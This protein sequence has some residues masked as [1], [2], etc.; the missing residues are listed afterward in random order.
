MLCLFAILALSSVQARPI[1]K[2]DSS[3]DSVFQN[4][5]QTSGA[6]AAM[7]PLLLMHCHLK[8]SGFKLSRSFW[9]STDFL[10]WVLLGFSAVIWTTFVFLSAYVYQDMPC[11]ALTKWACLGRLAYVPWILITAFCFWVLRLAYY[12]CFTKWQSTKHGGANPKTQTKGEPF[13]RWWNVESAQRLTDRGFDVYIRDYSHVL[14]LAPVLLTAVGAFND[15]QYTISLLNIVGVIIFLHG[16]PEINVYGTSPHTYDAHCIRIPL[17]TDLNPSFIYILPSTKFGFD[18]VYSRRIDSEYLALDKNKADLK[19]S[20]SCPE[21]DRQS[22]IAKYHSA[23]RDVIV[24]HNKN[25]SPLPIKELEH[26]A[27]WLCPKTGDQPLQLKT[28]RRVKD[29]NLIGRELVMALLHCEN[30]VFENSL[31]LPP[32]LQKEV[33]KLR[34]AENGGITDLLN[35][36]GS[37]ED[38]RESVGTYLSKV[39]RCFLSSWGKLLSRAAPAIIDAGVHSPS[40]DVFDIQEKNLYEVSEEEQD[41]PADVTRSQKGLHGFC[42]AV[43]RVYKIFGEDIVGETFIHE[44]F[45]RGQHPPEKSVAFK[46]TPGTMESYIEKLWDACY[47]VD[48]STFGALYLWSSVWYMEMGN[49]NGYH[50]T[51]FQPKLEHYYPSNWLMGWRDIWFI[52]VLSQLL[53]MLPT[54]LSYFLGSAIS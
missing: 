34:P 46:E 51:P 27:R 29:A 24:Q 20:Y 49:G 32:P 53:S 25:V 15:G 14:V 43:K 40:A 3:T 7:I 6:L 5:L 38:N 33:W 28:C 10:M 48:P 35:I 36:S 21:G 44:N 50:I 41:G 37:E 42:A 11:S 13:Q 12:T 47:A 30:L 16:V 17:V 23:M 19:P 2:R 22:W 1:D 26:L 18:A 52:A 8:T 54:I 39:W 31:R 45:I 4:T 9:T